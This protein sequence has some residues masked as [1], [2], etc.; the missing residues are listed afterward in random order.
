[1]LYNI[2]FL[3]IRGLLATFR[4]R[5]PSESTPCNSNNSPFYTRPSNHYYA[6]SLILFVH[7]YILFTAVRLP[8]PSASTQYSTMY[9]LFLL[10]NVKIIYTVLHTYITV[11]YLPYTV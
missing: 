5:L 9:T 10:F 7:A 8:F 2:D 6:R 1:M 4:L 11:P 3:S